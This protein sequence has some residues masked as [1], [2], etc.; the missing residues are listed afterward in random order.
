MTPVTRE[1]L[2]AEAECQ[3]LVLDDSDVEAVY[4]WVGRVTAAL[5]GMRS[6]DHAATDE[7]GLAS[8]YLVVSPDDLA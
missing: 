8:P 6:T 1:W 5:A 7:D 3:G 4:A 2:R